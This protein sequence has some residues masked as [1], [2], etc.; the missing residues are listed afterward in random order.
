MSEIEE[1]R[2][3][4]KRKMKRRIEVVDSDMAAGKPAR[5]REGKNIARMVARELDCAPFGM[6]VP[7]PVARW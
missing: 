2:D 1:V 7:I 5:K 3:G 4:S 6:K